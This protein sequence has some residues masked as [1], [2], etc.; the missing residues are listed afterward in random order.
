[1]SMRPGMTDYASILF[2]DE[3]A[4]LDQSGDPIEIYRRHIMPIKFSH[5]ER[6]S[7]E[8]GVVTDL[9]IILATTLLLTV[10]QVPSW[11]GIERELLAAPV[12]QGDGAAAGT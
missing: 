12:L 11:L 9:R 7:R 5:Y 8:V 2:R 1:V 4:L 6:Y 10:G 3:S